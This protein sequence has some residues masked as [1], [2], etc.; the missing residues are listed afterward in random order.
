MICVMGSRGFIF[1]QWEEI[2]AVCN[3]AKLTSR[4]LQ[5]W[6]IILSRVLIFS[7][8]IKIPLTAPISTLF[9]NQMAFRDP[10]LV[11]AGRCLFQHGQHLK[12]VSDNLFSDIIPFRPHL[13][14]ML[15]LSFTCCFSAKKGTRSNETTRFLFVSRPRRWYVLCLVSP[16]APNHSW[17]C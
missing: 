16:L 9:P 12:D 6:C 10:A 1:I 2:L 14:F 3:E 8:K 13:L 11:L 7:K 4:Y 17:T 5:S 15:L